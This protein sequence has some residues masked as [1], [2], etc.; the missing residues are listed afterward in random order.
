MS[1]VLAGLALY[2]IALGMVQLTFLIG[3]GW[4]ETR[5]ARADGSGPLPTWRADATFAI[6]PCLNEELVV[7]ETVRCLVDHDPH[8]RIVVVD[9]A[10]DDRTSS[11]AT[12]AGG[13]RVTVV[14]R[15]IPAA[16]LGKGPALNAAFAHINE[17]VDAEGLDPA[18]VIIIVMDADGRLSEGALHTVSDLF[19]DDRVGGAQ[20]GVRIRN[21]RDNLLATIQDCEFWGIAALGQMGRMRTRTVSL[22][23]NGQFTRLSA[24]RSIGDEPWSRAL[25]E[26]LDLAVTLAVGGWHLVST[27]DA[28]VSQQGLTAIRPLIKQ[29]TRWFQGHMTAATTRL[30]DVWR[31][32]DLSNSAVLEMTSY[33]LIPFAIVLPWSVLSQ[34]GI[35]T[36]AMHLD[37][38]APS[39]QPVGASLG[40]R[41][42]V[43]VLL[44]Y[45]FSFAPT[46]L[47]GWIYARREQDISVVRAVLFSHLL[48]LWNYVLFISCWRAVFR[49]VLGRTGWDKTAR[50]DESARDAVGRVEASL[51]A[52]PVASA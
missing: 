24:L 30:G 32:P 36:S 9:D 50:I 35:V 21:R 47:C 41:W 2:C 6:V 20:L 44:W 29:R 15:E 37:R 19:E 46:L 23:G 3:L 52:E 10:S 17:V 45:L 14:R 33:L 12:A 40:P 16:R 8:L 43:P 42:L 34:I 18:N 49:L 48:V 38:L 28:W 39:L 51:G 7:G 13:D 31:S 1:S 22:G 4:S 27:P 5:R 26:D 25:T 11:V